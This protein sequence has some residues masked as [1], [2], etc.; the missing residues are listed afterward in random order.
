MLEH[1]LAYIFLLTYRLI[2]V[3]FVTVFEIQYIGVQF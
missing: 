3:K 2:N 1:V